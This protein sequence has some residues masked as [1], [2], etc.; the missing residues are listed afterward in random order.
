MQI[1]L[2]KLYIYIFFLISFLYLFKRKYICEYGTNKFSYFHMVKQKYVYVKC[3]DG[4]ILCLASLHTQCINKFMS[5]LTINVHGRMFII[6]F[7]T[8]HACSSI[9]LVNE[10]IGEKKIE[11]KFFFSFFFSHENLSFAPIILII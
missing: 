5:E 6:T 4:K 9:F 7:Y 8:A 2:M 10:N 1:N 3:V 11:K